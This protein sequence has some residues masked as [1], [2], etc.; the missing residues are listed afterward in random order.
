MLL[1]R[2]STSRR[3]MLV[4]T[5][6]R[7]HT[8]SLCISNCQDIQTTASS[9]QYKH[10]PSTTRGN[11]VSTPLSS[12]SSKITTK[13]QRKISL[14]KHNRPQN[15]LLIRK[16]ACPTTQT[17][18]IRTTSSSTTSTSTTSSSTTP[19]HPT[20]SQMTT[21]QISPVPEPSSRTTPTMTIFPTPS[22]PTVPT[23]PTAP[24]PPHPNS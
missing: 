17:T 13:P 11:S 24:S 21:T 23:A 12:K 16:E 5:G 9:K 22:A 7:A 19:S 1:S 15:K 10:L 8:L 6:G 20:A 14:S 18:S 3:V 2:R 4:S